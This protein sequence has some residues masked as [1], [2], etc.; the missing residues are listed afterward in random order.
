V[1]V[2]EELVLKEKVHQISINK[3]EGR[4]QL[5]LLGAG[6]SGKSTFYMQLKDIYGTGFSERDFKVKFLW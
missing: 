4:I 1:A 6:E 5:L 3:P 2:A